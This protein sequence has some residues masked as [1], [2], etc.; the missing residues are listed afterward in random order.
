MS[1]LKGSTILF[2]T[3]NEGVEQAELE[4]PWKHFEAL[5]ARPVL[6]APEAGTVQAF[7]HLDRGD[8]FTATVAT[9]SLD[10]LGAVAGIV[11][12]GGVPNADAIRTDE[13]ATK[14]LRAAAESGT[15]VAVICHGAWLL[16]EA[17]EVEGRTLTSWPSLQTDLRNAGATWVDQE[18]V[19]CDNG[20]FTLV[21]SRKPDDLDAFSEN[22]Q[23]VFEQAHI[24][25]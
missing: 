3:A 14:Y 20:A 25:A 5:G 4:Q 7:N 17:D 6:A 18:V 8:Q 1:T 16:I 22:A 19:V 9:S 12:P 11:L 10:T 21:S 15:P 13:A 2:I 23:R 24:T